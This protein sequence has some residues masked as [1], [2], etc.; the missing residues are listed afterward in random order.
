MKFV[1]FLAPLSD[2]FVPS[3]A[4]KT[5]N[6]ANFVIFIKFAI[7]LKFAVFQALPSISL[8]L[9]VKQKFQIFAKLVKLQFLFKYLK[10]R[11]IL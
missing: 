4:I 3:C 7:F 8:C 5:A 9:A 1:V 10:R 2:L 6:I 11:T